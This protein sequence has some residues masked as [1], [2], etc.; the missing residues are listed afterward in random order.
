MEAMAEPLKPSGGHAI[1]VKLKR[2]F[3]DADPPPAEKPM[4]RDADGRFVRGTSGGPGFNRAKR[5]NL[6]EI[7]TKRA[8]ELGSTLNERLAIVIDALFV[9]ASLGDVAAAKLLF[10]KLGEVEAQNINLSVDLPLEERA[11]RV[12][13]LLRTAKDR[14]IMQQLLG[15]E[16]DAE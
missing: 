8:L 11:R 4:K 14:R 1:H 7:A 10:D 6:V 2:V 5:A 13:E 3:G 15:T 9:Q 12:S 16:P